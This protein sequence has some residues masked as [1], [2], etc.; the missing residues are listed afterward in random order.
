MN[1]F[2][3]SFRTVSCAVLLL[4][5]LAAL[6]A[7]AACAQTDH[8]TENRDIQVG[9]DGHSRLGAWF[10]IFV[11]TDDSDLIDSYS[12]ETVDADGFPVTFEGQPV[13]HPDG[14]LE[15]LMRA[16]RKHGQCHVHLNSGPETKN[17]HPFRLKDSSEKHVIHP[18][19]QGLTVVVENGTSI[20][21]TIATQVSITRASESAIVSVTESSQ[22]PSN[23]LGWQSVE[24]LIISA[25]ASEKQNPISPEQWL[26]IR[27]WVERGGN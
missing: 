21:S 20:A 22:L 3:L 27:T 14:W 8:E 12:I 5:L 16:G 18:S 10:P 7:D 26:A 1:P 4:T 19:T 13:R 15:C 9:F 17:S 6:G 25:S 23:W 24:R 2:R 11:H